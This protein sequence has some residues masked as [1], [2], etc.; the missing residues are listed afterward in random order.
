MLPGE[1]HTHHVHAWLSL[2]RGH[3]LLSSHRVFFQ[4][5]SKIAMQN[6]CKG[7]DFF[8]HPN[9]RLLASKY[10]CVHLILVTITGPFI[11]ASNHHY[12]T[13]LS[14]IKQCCCC[15]S[16]NCAAN[17]WESRRAIWGYH[18]IDKDT[19]RAMC[20]ERVCPKTLQVEDPTSR[21]S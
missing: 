21:Q 1:Q 7:P 5:P 2:S 4:S 16:L 18:T 19:K 10:F 12:T 8:E 14:T 3:R 13:K 17:T 11:S 20:V 15:L 9:L 6:Q